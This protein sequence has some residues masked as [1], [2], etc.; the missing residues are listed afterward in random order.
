MRA[1]EK[2]TFVR[3]LLIYMGISAL[4]FVITSLYYY[5]DQT[6]QIE[7]AIAKEMNVYGSYFRENQ[8][9]AESKEYGVKLLSKGTL[10]YPAFLDING[11]YVS[12]SC[13]GLD[14][15]HKI[16]AIYAKPEVIANK[17][18]RIKEKIFIFMSLAF[19]ANLFIAFFLAWVSMQPVRKKNQEFEEFV[20][21]VIHDLNAP[22]SAISINLESLSQKCQHKQIVRIGKSVDTIRNLYSNLEVILKSSYK[23]EP[24]ILNIQEYTQS[25]VEQLQPLYPEITF[26]LQMPPL[27]VKIDAFAFERI[28]VNLIQNASKYTQENPHVILGIDE[29]QRF[30]IRDNGTGISDLNLLKRAKQSQATNKGYGLGLSIVQKLSEDCGISFVIESQENEGTT[31]YFDISQQIMNTK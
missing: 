10:P 30:F 8:E 24:K 26:T 22:I 31:F 2:Q 16:V 25:I 21:D 27:Q 29:Q 5:Y 4:L 19:I 12:T 3:F 11:S 13:G 28:L 14:F 18:K 1:S 6:Q 20:D 23:S 15:P 17:K 7:D 9:F